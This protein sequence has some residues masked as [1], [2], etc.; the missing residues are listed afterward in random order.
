VAMGG[1]ISNATIGALGIN[2]AAE[3]PMYQRDAAHSGYAVASRVNA[4]NIT[5]LNQSWSH[6]TGGM[7][8]ATPVVANGLVY[9][10]SWDGRMYALRES[11]GQLVWSL[12]AGRA[13]DNCGATY[14]IDSTAA[15]VGGRLYFGAANC[16]LYSVNAANGNVI[17]RTQLGDA[18]KGYHLWSS[19]LVF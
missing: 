16:S 7:V 12:D 8:T 14:G 10:G 1:R 4:T 11:D 3:W 17:W 19:P 5:N 9:A 13:T 18:T 6:Q 2:A 15:V